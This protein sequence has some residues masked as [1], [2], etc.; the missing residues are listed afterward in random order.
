MRRSKSETPLQTSFHSAHPLDQASSYYKSKIESLRTRNKHK[1]LKFGQISKTD[2]FR[3]KKRTLEGL[4]QLKSLMKLGPKE[5][6]QDHHK[7]EFL[8]EDWK[9]ARGRRAKRIEAQLNKVRSLVPQARKNMRDRSDMFKGWELFDRFEKCLQKS[10]IGMTDLDLEIKDQNFLRNHQFYQSTI[11]SLA[12]EHAEMDYKDELEMI[13][14]D[15]DIKKAKKIALINVY[16]RQATKN[17]YGNHNAPLLNLKSKA[18]MA[19]KGFIRVNKMK[20]T[21]NLAKIPQSYRDLKPERKIEKLDMFSQINIPVRGRTQ[22]N[23]SHYL[24]SIVLINSS[25]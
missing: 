14:K 2:R 12:K 4:Q 17:I 11:N 24:K 5:V 16:S 3:L 23:K 15:I 9:A 6:L 18:L 21:K 22:A 19:R 1:V 13:K 8:D 7:E 25:Y 20:I 10:E